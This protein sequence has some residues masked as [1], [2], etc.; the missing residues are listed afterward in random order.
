MSFSATLSSSTEKV[1]LTYIDQ[2]STKFLISKD[3]LLSLWNGGVCGSSNDAAIKQQLLDNVPK[4]LAI[5]T[6]NELVEMC[7]TKKLK[8]SGTKNELIQRIMLSEKEVKTQ[9]LMTQ[10]GL[11]NTAAAAAPKLITKPAPVVL[12]KN[13]FGNFEDAETHFVFN[14]KTKKVFGKQ[15]PDGSISSLT[16]E[17][18]NICNKF[19]LAFDVPTN[20]KQE[21]G[22]KAELAE[23]DEEDE[24]EVEVEIEE[25]DEE[26][27]EEEE[28]IEVELEIDDDE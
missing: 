11:V 4:E 18:I 15:N 27:E 9:P 21:E 1:V 22:D 8:H 6:R 2:I 24:E 23:L 17:D 7:K 14:E 26:E 25:D 19:K 12:T 10:Q 13:K 28:E 3:D 5:L 16:V 20:L